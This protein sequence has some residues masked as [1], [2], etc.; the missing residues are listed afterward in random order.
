MDSFENVPLCYECFEQLG[1]EFNSPTVGLLEGNCDLCGKR[2]SEIG[3]PGEYVMVFVKELNERLVSV[4]AR[5]LESVAGQTIT[6]PH[7]DEATPLP[8]F[9]K[10]CRR[11]TGISR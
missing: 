6:H 3:K 8:V 11:V 5:E 7:Q 2:V 10:L 1:G 4:V 9:H